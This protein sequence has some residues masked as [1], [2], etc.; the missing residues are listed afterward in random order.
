MVMKSELLWV[1]VPSFFIVVAS[2]VIRFLASRN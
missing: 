1:W 2:T